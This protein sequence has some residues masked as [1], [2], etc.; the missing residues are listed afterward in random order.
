LYPDEGHSDP[1]WNIVPVKLKN[2][3]HIKYHVPR[4]EV[5]YLQTSIEKF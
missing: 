2:Q 3:K 1:A 5:T 4:K